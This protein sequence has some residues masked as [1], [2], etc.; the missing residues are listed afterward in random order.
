[1][2]DA[3]D[4]V[5]GTIKFT[6]DVE[7]PEM[8][9]AR[10]VRST[11]PHA[12]LVDVD[13]SEALAMPGVITVVTG[14]TLGEIPLASH[15]Y[16]EGRKDQPIVAIDKVRYVGDPVAIVIAESEHIANEAAQFVDVE[17][18]ELP[19]VANA[20]DAALPGATII[21]DSWPDNNCGSWKLRHGDIERGWAE[22][23]FI[24]ENTF[25]S[26]TANHVTMEPHVTL[27]SVGNDMH[28]EIWTSTQSPH[29]IRNSIAQLLDL[30]PEKVRV[31]APDLG[32]GYGAKAGNK[33]EPLVV[34]AAMQAKRPVRLALTREEVFLTIAK[35]EARVTIKT[36]VKRDGTLVARH[37]DVNWNAGAYA[38]TTP[39]TSKQG[40]IRAPG[41][42]R[43]PNVSIDSRAYYTNTVPTGA[44][45]GAMSSQV[46][47]AYES[48]LDEIAADLDLDPIEIRRKNLL[49]DGDTF[50]TGEVMKDLFFID[51]LEEVTQGIG[52]NT[53][54]EDGHFSSPESSVIK[55]GRGVGLLIKHTATPSRS[56]AKLSLLGDG[57]CVV[58]SSSVEMGQGA[59]TS[60]HQFV[61]DELGIPLEAIGGPHP[62]TDLTPFDSTTSSSRT[63]YAM[64]CAL[65]EAAEDL[66]RQLKQLAADIWEANPDDVRVDLGDVWSVDSP[67]RKVSFSELLSHC[68]VDQLDGHGEFRSPEGWGI[69]D[70][71]G[72]GMA[73][74]HWHQGAVAVEVEVDTST[75][76]V[77]V[78][79]C[80]A[81]AYAGRMLNPSL[82]RQQNEGN[83]IF[84]LGPSLFEQYVLDQGELI[85][86]NLSDYMIPSIL[87]IP[88]QLSS[89]GIESAKAD[90]EIHGVGEMT[91]PPVAPAIRN[92]IFNA[93]GAKI[94]DLPM[95][96]ER[97]YR[98][99]RHLG[100]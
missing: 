53:D 96:A 54:K 49:R 46:C 90:A 74:V 63:A 6:L 61:A 68:S 16:G 50:A 80:H 44:F 82:V 21:H 59:R 1:M 37:V 79:R 88:E 20:E 57:T 12:N 52:W 93:T 75:G 67:D 14:K 13:A 89:K 48:Q 47:W 72:Q 70:E 45:R 31:H 11:L 33:L 34:A 77:K 98:S 55:R 18:D 10:V 43:I 8:A 17:Y 83:V 35:H 97:V 73:T 91:L 42:Y 26:P 56:E 32:G 27:V 23:D 9:H 28:V 84:G 25:S 78:N 38:V 81:A 60:L 39:R 85:N 15:Y 99:L 69:L 95:T 76:K 51:L 7:L 22:S 29:E 71:N 66:K 41:P 100:E 5:S 2:R 30:N 86:P 3:I 62:D 65:H 4:R 64:T 40:M 36:G 92:A 58:Y 94:Y 24:Y 19:W 87:D